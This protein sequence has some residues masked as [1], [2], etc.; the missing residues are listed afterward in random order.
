MTTDLHVV[1]KSVPR[2]DGVG[3]DFAYALPC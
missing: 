1:G 2:S 3:F